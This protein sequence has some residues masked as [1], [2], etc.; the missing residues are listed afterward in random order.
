[1]VI[2]MRRSALLAVPLTIAALALPSWAVAQPAPGTTSTGTT[3][4]TTGTTT[5][6][7]STPAYTG[8]PRISGLRLRNVV[9]AQQGHARFMLGLKSAGPA[10]VTIKITS[11]KEKKVVRTITSAP[12]EP[13]GQVWF[14]V[15]A[16]NDQGYQLPNGAYSVSI[17]A[18]DA[19]GR[20]AKAL[21]R[22][23][24][25]ELTPPRGRLDGFTVPNLP[26]IARQLK[27]PEGGQLVTALGPKG[28]LVTA[29]LRRGDVITKI[30]SLDVTTPGQWTAALKALPADTPVPVE[31]RRGAEVRTGT[32]SVPADWNPAPSYEKTFPV[33]VKRNP[34][35]LGYLLAAARD[36][37]DAG[38][39]DDAQ[40]LFN[41][42][43]KGLQSTG[44]GQMLQ[45]EILL[46]KD[47][48]KGALAAYNRAVKAD[49]NL[50]PA[51]LGQGLVL[52]RLDRTDEAVPAFQAAVAADPGNAIAQAF[53]AYALIA[54]DQ[55]DAAI[56]AATEAV[57]LDAN[58]E[59]GYV[60][61]G[62]ALIATNQKA[63]GVAELKKGLL[64]ISDDKRAT[65]LITDNLEPNHP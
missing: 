38:K 55:F 54:T 41:K 12:D 15:Q 33:L 48:L 34:G 37:I 9:K 47:D 49:P 8:P 57:R 4:A 20:T 46:D 64:L 32:I 51:L 16:V 6:T 58:Y 24:K 29:G 44:V 3:P 1:M 30:N 56:A 50:A 36:R 39:P 23:F 2:A 21:K 45:G 60:A 43:P 65:Q 59:D 62:L 11:L 27:I 25:L 31:Y 63:K 40:K 53:L 5:P 35:K 22:N 13:G 61:L 14:L 18:T 52:S 19:Q 7:T 42:W 26:A 17:S 28:V 10:T